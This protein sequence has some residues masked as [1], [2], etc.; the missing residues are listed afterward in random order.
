M[1]DNLW[2]DVLDGVPGA[3]DEEEEEEIFDLDL[4]NFG[5]HLETQVS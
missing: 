4:K 1:T 3:P 5:L 2:L